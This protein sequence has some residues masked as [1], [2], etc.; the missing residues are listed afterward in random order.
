M[1]DVVMAIIPLKQTVTVRKWLAD[2]DDGWANED[3]SAPTTYK[4]RATEKVEIVTNQLGEEKTA[5]VKLLFD[6]LPDITYADEITYINEMDVKVTRTP[7][8]IKPIRMI[9]GKPTLTAIYL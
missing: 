2:N 5:S 1:G 9:N 8:S 3:W 4:V 6:K 7:L